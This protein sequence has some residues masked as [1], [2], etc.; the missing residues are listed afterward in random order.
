MFA[1]YLKQNGG[2]FILDTICA[3]KLDVFLFVADNV[4]GDNISG[5]DGLP[6]LEAA[7]R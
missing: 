2:H 4:Y 3:K 7:C 6:Q 1:C 5:E